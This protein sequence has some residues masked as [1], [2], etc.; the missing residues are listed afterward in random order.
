METVTVYTDEGW[1][2][3]RPPK[4]DTL[5]PPRFE[6]LWW[7]STDES[8]RFWDVTVHLLSVRNNSELTRYSGSP[9][10]TTQERENIQGSNDIQV[11]LM[12]YIEF[13][14][15]TFLVILILIFRF[16][17]KLVEITHIKCILFHTSHYSKYHW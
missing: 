10:E 15:L 11:Y 4:T 8:G 12:V 1:R 3:H 9:Q 2:K 16:L 14:Q 13:H 6:C 7:S 17:I 5:S